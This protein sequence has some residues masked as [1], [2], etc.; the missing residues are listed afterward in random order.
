MT[1]RCL[2]CCMEVSEAGRSGVW[3]QAVTE[4]QASLLQFVRASVRLTWWNHCVT[5]P[6]HVT[7]CYPSIK[8]EE[9]S[10]LLPR[11]SLR[12]LQKRTLSLQLTHTHTRMDWI[13]IPPFFLLWWTLLNPGH[14][15]CLLPLTSSLFFFFCF[16]FS[17]QVCRGFARTLKWWLVSSRTDSGESAGPLWLQPSWRYI[18]SYAVRHTDTHFYIG[19]HSDMFSLKRTCPILLLSPFKSIDLQLKRS[20]GKKLLLLHWNRNYFFLLIP[21]VLPGLK[22]FVSFK[23]SFCQKG[24]SAN[25]NIHLFPEHASCKKKKKKPIICHLQ[26]SRSCK[27]QYVCLHVSVRQWAALMLAIVMETTAAPKQRWR[28]QMSKS[29]ADWSSR[30]SRGRSHFLWELIDAQHEANLFLSASFSLF[31]LPFLRLFLILPSQLCCME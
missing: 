5:L 23:N 26:C 7:Q 19:T 24:L 14:P 1:T 27:F 3:Q 20:R 15:W 22:L 6:L 17:V 2:C 18:C 25:A 10:H 8:V 11:L 12:E 28:L 21:V 9:W 31:L 30:F 16:P 29:R 4:E 13:G